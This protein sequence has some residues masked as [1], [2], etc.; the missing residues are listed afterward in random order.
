MNEPYFTKI[1]FETQWQIQKYNIYR[2]ECTQ[3]WQH[4]KYVF[5]NSTWDAADDNTNSY[6]WKSENV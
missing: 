3:D 5:L 4:K 1:W 2:S 6:A